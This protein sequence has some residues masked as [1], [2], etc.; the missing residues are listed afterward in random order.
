MVNTRGT[1]KSS[2]P[3]AR[4]GF[5]RPWSLVT[6]LKACELDRQVTGAKQALT[7]IKK[8]IHERR[9]DSGDYREKGR[10]FLNTIE[11]FIKFGKVGCEGGRKPMGLHPNFST[12]TSVQ[13]HLQVVMFLHLT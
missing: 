9:R 12:S 11:H 5:R 4:A 7:L 2:A 1:K 6:F 3:G 13:L 8:L 10:K